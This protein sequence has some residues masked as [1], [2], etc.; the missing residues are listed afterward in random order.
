MDKVHF[1][2]L[3]VQAIYEYLHLWVRISEVQLSAAE[4]VYIWRWTSNGQYTSKSAYAMLHQGSMS[5]SGSQ[6]IWKSWAPQKIKF[7][8]WL[9]SRKKN[10]ELIGEGAMDFKRMTIV[11]SAT[12]NMKQQTTSWS[13]AAMRRKY[14][15]EFWTLLTASVASCRTF[16]RSSPGGNI[17]EEFSR[18][19]TA[20][21]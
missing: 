11:G 20:K 13:I 9:A 14:G 15:G 4:D 6:R 7:F 8:I 19:H 5:F 1:W 12:K 18:E 16:P 2:S 17:W 10:L 3:T 21:V